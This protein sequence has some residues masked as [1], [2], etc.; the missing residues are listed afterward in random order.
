MLNSMYRLNVAQADLAQIPDM[1]AE[2]SLD[3]AVAQVPD[4]YWG[5]VTDTRL[6][7]ELGVLIGDE[8]LQKLTADLHFY[9]ATR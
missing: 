6:L 8:K 4:T 7:C 3:C 1:I 5:G 2:A 9:L